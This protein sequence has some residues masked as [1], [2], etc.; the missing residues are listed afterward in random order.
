MYKRTAI[1]LPDFLLTHLEKERKQVHLS[2]SGF[3]RKAIESFLGLNSIIDKGLLK[4][5][6]SIYDTLN[7]ENKNL[8]NQM[9]DH[10]MDTFPKD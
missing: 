2:R 1:T 10:T 8:S 5:Y 7:K 3:I 9:L 6:G 4:K